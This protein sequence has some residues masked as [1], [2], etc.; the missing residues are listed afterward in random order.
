MIAKHVAMQSAEK[1]SS[2][3]LMEYITSTQDKAHR[4][5]E[6]FITNCLA[7]SPDLAALEMRAVQDGNSRASG[8]K[9]YHLLVSF[10]P[11][12]EPAPETLRAIEQSMCERLGFAEHQRVAVVH[13][14]TDSLHMH[15]VINKIHPTRFTMRDPF[16]DHVILARAGGE[17]ERL[18]HLRPDNHTPTGK[19]K[20]ERK[21]GDLE[22]MTGQESLLSWM[23]REC[24][25]AMRAADSWEALHREAAK[26]GL[27][28][29][30]RGN[31]MVF[32]SASGDAVKASDVDRGLSKGRLE[33]RFGTFRPA[34]DF[35]LTTRPEKT[36]RRE[37]L[38]MANLLKTEF[39]QSRTA[40]T[41]TRTNRLAEIREEQHRRM[42]ALRAVGQAERLRIR[43]LPVGK[44]KKR[45]LFTAVNTK[46]R[47]DAAVIREDMG[48]R[49]DAAKREHPRHTWLSWLQ[50]QAAAGRREAIRTLRAR[51]FG[52]ARKAGAALRGDSAAGPALLPGGAV[53]G[54]T[55][56]GTV[57]Y[58]V[59]D[60]ALRDDGD[61]FRVSRA[62]G[63][64]TAI[65]A[66]KLARERYGDA[67]R[68]DGDRAFRERMLQAA[69]AGRVGIRF[70]DP[71]LEAKRVELLRTQSHPPTRPKQR[72]NERI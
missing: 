19:T 68:I 38:G 62:A 28:L 10:R 49:R 57:I 72:G 42:A 69:V 21:A 60:D 33:K 41:R 32:I 53:D 14:D 1:S 47:R 71:A 26:A 64:D 24:L 59:G 25:P 36:Y 40:A 20:G 52:L 27:A 18:H 22:A 29:A 9:T 54:V 8:D 51:A 55:K 56:R 48:R 2:I 50:E 5:G 37:P 67:L 63:L 39:E 13:R 35:D 17:L 70:T 31:G 58:R 7:E 44:Q 66:L 45:E 6:V 11:G 61:S 46:Y 16:Q 34:R 65:L 3:R 30:L 12:E 15:I 43:R 4:V 23:R